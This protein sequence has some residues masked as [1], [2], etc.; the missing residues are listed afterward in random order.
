MPRL[1]PTLARLCAAAFALAA[2]LGATANIAQAQTT[3]GNTL[4]AD[5]PVIVDASLGKPVI[6]FGAA[7]SVKRTPVIFV[8]GNNDTPFPTAC[9][10]YGRMQAVAQYLAD[11]G[12]Y[13]ASELVGVWAIRVTNAT[14]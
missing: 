3:I 9:N 1:A 11:A 2:L 13:A 10:P 4:P 12:G 7:G 8:H 14:C 5:F 6:G